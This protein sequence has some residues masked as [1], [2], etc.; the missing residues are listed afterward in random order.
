[1]RA[2]WL[3]G[4]R[5]IVAGCL[6]ACGPAPLT[7][8]P[9]GV[10]DVAPSERTHPTAAGE[11]THPTAAGERTD[12]TAAGERTG[13]GATRAAAQPGP[14]VDVHYPGGA[15]ETGWIEVQRFEPGRGFQP[16]PEHPRIRAGTT[17]P[18]ERDRL[19]DLQV[20]CFDPTGRRPASGWVVGVRIGP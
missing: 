20:R 15:C 11:R 13:A 19:L 18:E 14:R 5:S 10:A 2:G 7:S 1:M 12:P 17:W 8:S 3:V 4:W 6:L 9:P 16:H